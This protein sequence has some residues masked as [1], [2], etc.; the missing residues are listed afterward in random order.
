MSQKNWVLILIALIW[1]AAVCLF[2]FWAVKAM[3]APPPGI[4]PNSPTSQWFKSLR[5]PKNNSSC[6][7]VA[8]C[9]RAIARYGPGY[10]EVLDKDTAAWLPVPQDAIIA[11]AN[12]TGEPVVCIYYGRVMCFV[13]GIES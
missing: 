2:T 4:D 9:G 3:A 12:P 8:D 6:C 10:I 5:Q 1:L 7:D 11:T 13:R